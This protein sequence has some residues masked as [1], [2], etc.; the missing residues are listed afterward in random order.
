MGNNTKNIM[1]VGVGGQGT[2]LTSR[3]LGGITVDAGFDVK[4]SEVHGMAQRGG[5]VVTF[6][7]Y[8]EKVA[9]PIVEEGQADVLIAFERLE[10]L[11]YAHFLKKD[12]VLVVNEQRIDPITVVTGAATYPE[13]IVE[14]LEK[15][16]SVLKINAMDEALKLGN[17]KVFNIIVLGMAAKH[18]DFSKED[19]LKVIEKT[20]PP[21]TVDMNKKA[22]L[23]G[24]EGGH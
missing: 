8:G 16:Y 19:W 17:S 2:L 18:M 21:K 9:E 6:V 14:E 24:F 1:I 4:L 20:V 23:L 22:F 10:A 15:E 11:R 7:R 3:I 13:G 5:S 12:G